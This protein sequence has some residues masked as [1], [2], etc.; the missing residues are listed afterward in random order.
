[1]SLAVLCLWPGKSPTQCYPV[2]CTHFWIVP[3]PISNLPRKSFKCIIQEKNIPLQRL[4][5]AVVVF[6]PIKN[7]A[8]W[9]RCWG[10]R[11]S[12]S[13]SLLIKNTNQT[14]VF[15]FCTRFQ[16]L[17]WLNSPIADVTGASGEFSIIPPTLK[18]S[19]YNFGL[20][21]GGHRLG[22]DLRVS[23]D[24]LGLALTRAGFS[25]AS[26]CLVSTCLWLSCLGLFR[27]LNH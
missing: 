15:L 21:I 7:L 10:S 4:Q 9:P 19:K 27:L 6:V 1:M 14:H 2:I 5:S 25:R 18:S 8:Q 22:A 12:D 16:V 26:S 17:F 3:S 24:I 13:H 11:L 20:T 23:Q